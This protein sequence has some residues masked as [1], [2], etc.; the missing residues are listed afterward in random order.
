[1]NF[2]DD[3]WAFSKFRDALEIVRGPTPR[4]TSTGTR[5]QPKGESLASAS[6]FAS[7]ACPHASREVTR[8][9]PPHNLCHDLCERLL[10]AGTD[11]F[12]HV[13]SKCECAFM[14]PIGS[15]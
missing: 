9:R 4:V 7:L 11:R 14:H 10:R 13:V 15:D 6:T 12:G 8:V 3:R 5:V 2:D 1:M